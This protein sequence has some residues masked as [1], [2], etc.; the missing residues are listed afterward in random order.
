M[1]I[2]LLCLRS[3]KNKEDEITALRQLMLLL[4]SEDQEGRMLLMVSLT[5]AKV[6]IH[7]LIF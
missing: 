4:K 5:G 7:L 1:E 6:E 2:S 3:L